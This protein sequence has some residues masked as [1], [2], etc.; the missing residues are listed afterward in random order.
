MRFQIALI[1]SFTLLL[2]VRTMTFSKCKNYVVLENVEDF[3]EVATIYLEKIDVIFC[4]EQIHQCIS[5]Y[6][7]LEATVGVACM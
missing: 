3:A 2:V 7:S 1:T 4:E 6:K 5:A